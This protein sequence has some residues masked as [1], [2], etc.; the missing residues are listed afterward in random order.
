MWGYNWDWYS[1]SNIK[2]SGENYNFELHKV[3]AHD[4][5][6]KFSFK[7]Y[8]AFEN[9]TIP[10]TNYRDGYFINDKYSVSI[11]VDHMKYVMDQ[12]KY[13]RITGEIN[14]GGP[15]DGTYNNDDIQLLEE[16]LTFEHTDGLNY[17][18][19]EVTRNDELTEVFTNIKPIK[20]IDIFLQTGVGVGLIYP[21]SNVKLLDF[22]RYDQFNVAGWGANLK[23]GVNVSF[24]ENLFLQT[25]YKAG[26]ISMPNIRT[27]NSTNDKA[28]Q[29]FIFRQFNIA[30][31]YNFWLF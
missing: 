29:N 22:E 30:F 11:G 16:F 28:K 1:R 14:T 6:T 25:E 18:T 3:K 9:L 13:T 20:N 23:I 7:D 31:G 17:F 19:A 27:T 15:Y 10:Q 8:F 12:Y 4:R 5:Q 21:K 26:Y 24:W 2:F